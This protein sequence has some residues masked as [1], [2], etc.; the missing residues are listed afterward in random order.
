MA[1]R[2]PA[3]VV[4]NASG[5]RP[6][7]PMR[8][9][10]AS[11]SAR[12][13]SVRSSRSVLSS[14]VGYS[15]M[16]CSVRS[17]SASA[18]AQL[19]LHQPRRRQVDLAHPCTRYRHSDDP[20]G[21]GIRRGVPADESELLKDLHTPKCCPSPSLVL[22]CKELAPNLLSRDHSVSADPVQDLP[23]PIGD[24]GSSGNGDR[25]SPPL[26]HQSHTCG[27]S[28]SAQLWLTTAQHPKRNAPKVIPHPSPTNI[29]MWGWGAGGS[30]VHSREPTTG[31]M[32]PLTWADAESQP[33][34]GGGPA[35]SALATRR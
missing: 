27:P 1:M 20:G 35:Y 22:G 14:T 26:L 12:T 19:A 17:T 24:P 30:A 25:S 7:V 11:R 23:V 32:R 10:E 16:S 34:Q 18:V 33:G 6:R 5:H 9:P 3:G 31:A 13:R 4:S 2:S 8:R 29:T 21:A 28:T 15:A